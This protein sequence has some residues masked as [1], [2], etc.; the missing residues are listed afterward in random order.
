VELHSLHT[1][2]LL[3]ELCFHALGQLLQ[4]ALKFMQAIVCFSFLVSQFL[5]GT[6]FSFIKFFDR[7]QGKVHVHTPIVRDLVRQ[8]SYAFFKD[9]C[10]A[11]CLFDKL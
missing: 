11:G 1:Q 4:I 3:I 2:S 9:L 10:F 7:L 5:E 8:A 6:E